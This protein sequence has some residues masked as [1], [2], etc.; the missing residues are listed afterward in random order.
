M[1]QDQ[2]W[3]I[4]MQTLGLEGL[5]QQITSTDLFQLCSHMTYN[6]VYCNII[7]STSGN[8]DVC[9]DHSGCYVLIKSLKYREKGLLVGHDMIV[10]ISIAL[11]WAILTGFT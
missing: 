9:V 6:Q 5:N 11:G 10:Y 4:C 2:F 1:S 8:N 3:R 7:F